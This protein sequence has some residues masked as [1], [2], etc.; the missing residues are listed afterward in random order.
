MD[1]RN[2]R[3][4]AQADVLSQV[5]AFAGRIMVDVACDHRQTKLAV[6]GSETVAQIRRRALAE[7]EILAAQ[8]ERYLVIGAGHRR[9]NPDRTIDE[10]Q[11]E[12]EKLAF[13]FMRP[14]EF[15]QPEEKS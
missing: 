7:M 5:D 11:A 14:P 4:Q 3:A 9:I 6:S 8:P 15:G 2:P 13:R 10:L 1:E 12:G